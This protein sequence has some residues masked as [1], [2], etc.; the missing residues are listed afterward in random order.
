VSSASPPPV[1]LT[2]AVRE[3]L[4]IR[5]AGMLASPNSLHFRPP[6]DWHATRKANVDNHH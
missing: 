6:R 5:A 2:V 4:Q 3:S 1:P